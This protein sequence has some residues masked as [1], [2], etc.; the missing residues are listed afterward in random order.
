MGTLAQARFRAIRRALPLDLDTRC[1]AAMN[2]QQR[3]IITS[4]ISHQLLRRQ[5]YAVDLV[6]GLAKQ[7]D[8]RAAG[9]RA[10]RPQRKKTVLRAHEG[11]LKIGHWCA[12][13]Y[14]A[15]IVVPGIN[16]RP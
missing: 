7:C 4:R 8:P 9:H 13:G 10:S 1:F 15:A 14:I 3:K 16:A 12:N 2:C 6:E 11:P 5:R